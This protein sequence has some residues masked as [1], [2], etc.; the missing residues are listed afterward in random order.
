M[1]V[2]LLLLFVWDKGIVKF[3]V[4][5]TVLHSFKCH[6]LLCSFYAKEGRAGL[7]RI[8]HAAALEPPRGRNGDYLG[9]ATIVTA[10]LR[11][12]P[13]PIPLLPWHLNLA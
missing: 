7:S 11:V 10:R 8:E 12:V 9:A 1:T 13:S 4:S 6:N 3:T 2:K 5:L